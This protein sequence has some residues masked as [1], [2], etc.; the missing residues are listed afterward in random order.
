MENAFEILVVVLSSLL[1]IF[2]IIA[3]IVSV[4]VYK[5]V[6]A[7][8]EIVD[9]GEQFV[10]NAQEFSATFARNASAAGL[11]R[12]LMKFVAKSVNNKRGR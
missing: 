10:D 4:M 6:K 7:I 12:L 1:G 2:L 9:K 8:R 11:V 3:I 5:L